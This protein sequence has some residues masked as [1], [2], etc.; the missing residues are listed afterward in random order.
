[1]KGFFVDIEQAALENEDFRKVLYTGARLQLVVMAL[2]PG[3]DIG[4]E[5]HELDQFIRV[6]AGSGKAVLDGVEHAISDGSVVIVPQSARHN[7][8]NSGYAAMKL[9]TLYSPPNHRHGT[10]HKTKA[11]AQADEEHFDGTVSE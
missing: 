10:I 4:E 8:I 7:I 1:M 3:E 11:D 2:K 6:E 9:Y 5:V